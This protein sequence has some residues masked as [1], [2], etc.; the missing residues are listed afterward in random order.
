M[1]EPVCYDHALGCLTHF[2]HVKDGRKPTG[3]LVHLYFREEKTG[4]QRTQ[5]TCPES[6]C[7]KVRT[8][9][10]TPSFLTDPLQYSC[11]ENPHGQ[12]S[13]MGYSPWGL[14]ELG[15]KSR[16][17]LSDWTE[18]NWRVGHNWVTKHSTAESTFHE[19]MIKQDTN[20]YVC[21]CVCVCV[22]VGVCLCVLKRV[23]LPPVLSSVWNGDDR[24]SQF[25]QVEYI[26]LGMNVRR[27]RVG[28]GRED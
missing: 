13:L 20:K 12:R 25:Y 5:V 2:F 6:K 11:L 16:T 24:L 9:P 3:F 7:G 18:L 8:K 19:W 27:E 10:K 26:C 14:Q 1:V 28:E 15:A 21:V 4:M 23:E 17:W 22:W